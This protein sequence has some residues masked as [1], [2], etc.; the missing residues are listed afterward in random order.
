M[1]RGKVNHPKWWDIVGGPQKIQVGESPW[2]YCEKH[3]KYYDRKTGEEIQV[4]AISLVEFLNDC[5]LPCC[6]AAPLSES[7]ALARREAEG[8]K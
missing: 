2:H 1:I 6:K 8:E 4:K 3:N 5:K 7:Q